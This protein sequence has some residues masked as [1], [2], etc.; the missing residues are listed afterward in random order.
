MSFN[1]IP[2]S[3]LLIG[4]VVLF[5]LSAFFSGSETALMSLNRYKLRHQADQKHR[6]AMLAQKLL[7][8]PDRLIGL[9]LLGNNF[10][11]ILITQVATLLGLR[12][13]GDAGL[14]IAT[15]ILTL[16]LLIFAEVMPKTL[17]ALNPERLA[18]PAAHVYNVLLRIMYPL[19][20]LVNLIANSFLKFFGSPPDE[21][22]TLN[23]D[24]LRSVV[25]SAG[26]SIPKGHVDMLIRVLDLESTTI[27]DIMIARNHIQGIDL[28]DDWNDIE[29]QI[30]RSS[31]T[32][33]LVYRGN[34]DNILGFIHLRKLLSLL[35]EGKLDR[36]RLEGLIRPAYFVPEGTNL[37]QQLLNFRESSRRIAVV[38]DE[39]G[40]IQGLITIED[41]LEE[42]V[43]E[44]ST[45]PTNLIREVQ[46]MDDGS[47]WTDGAIHIRELNRQLE[48]DLPTDG[49]KTIN[50]L[51]TEHLQM[52]PVPGMTVLIQDYPLEIR[53]TRNN[54]VKTLIIHPKIQRK[55]LA[56]AMHG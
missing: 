11:N 2:I 8:T 42:I 37:T 12:L 54:A 41:I 31:F 51:I 36:E 46:K 9:I 27:E 55:I 39:Y 29:E 26:S 22:I 19:V 10:I 35:K 38:V 56:E 53:Q 6:G 17:A 1:E 43:G 23:R 33:V 5:A 45:V 52:I 3:F 4:L 44:F 13:F 20:W 30:L 18:F 28:D 40:D 7:D 48:I 49:P 34:L 14:A 16:L 21:N 25:N 24:E 32:R 15:G 47:Y 50:G